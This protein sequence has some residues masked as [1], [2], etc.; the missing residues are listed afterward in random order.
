MPVRKWDTSNPLYR[1]QQKN[2]GKKRKK[3]KKSVKRVLKK[4]K[5]R[6]V[7]AA[8]RARLKAMRKKFG[9]GEFSNRR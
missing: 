5:K 8:T 7:S 1:W 3:R 2:K 9:L 4:K 6:R